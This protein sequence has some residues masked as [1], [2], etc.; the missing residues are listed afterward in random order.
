VAAGA[1]IPHGNWL[2][3]VPTGFRE[4]S[5]G[6]V[7]VCKHQGA[8]PPEPWRPARERQRAFRLIEES[9]VIIDGTGVRWVVSKLRRYSRSQMGAVSSI[10]QT[11]VDA[12]QLDITR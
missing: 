4:A 7:P 11:D 3:K 5:T 6:E 12:D 2:P 1:A 8:G 10:V 9:A